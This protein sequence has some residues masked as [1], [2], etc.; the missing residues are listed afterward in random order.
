VIPALSPVLSWFLV[1]V[2]LFSAVVVYAAVIAG[3]RADEWAE[4]TWAIHDTPLRVY[5]GVYDYEARGDFHDPIRDHEWCDDCNARLRQAFNRLADLDLGP[6]DADA[7]MA[8]IREVL[9]S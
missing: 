9:D 5:G 7:L 1:L 2:V 6:R 8:R 4:R 3:G